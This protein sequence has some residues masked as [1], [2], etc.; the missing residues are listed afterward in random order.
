M[1]VSQSR[2]L[3]NVRSFFRLKIRLHEFWVVLRVISD[4][5]NQ[6]CQSAHQLPGSYISGMLTSFQELLKKYTKRQS[7]L[8]LKN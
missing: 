7:E 3:Y 2:E 5:L 8:T 1:A 4:Y 6:G